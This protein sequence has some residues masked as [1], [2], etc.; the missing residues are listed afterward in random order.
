MFRLQRAELRSSWSTWLGVS[1]AFI[2]TNFALVLSALTLVA[3]NRAVRSG[4]LDPLDSTAFVYNPAQNLVFSA[5]VG[6]VVIGTAT[7]LALS[8]R[9]GALARLALTGA[10]PAQIVGTVMVQL[11]VV[12]LASSLVG[13]LLA[14]LALTPT[15]EFLA[16]ERIQAGTPMPAPE[17]VYA[18][19]P[20]A[21][22]TLGAVGV[23]VLGGLRQ[24]VRGSRVAPVEA[25]RSH[26]A[27]GQRIRMTVG[28]VIASC[29]VLL[30]LAGC[31][32]AVALLVREPNKETVSNLVVL[33]MA[34]LILMA[35]LLALLAPVLIG[36]LTRAWV[37]LLP[38][39]VASWQLARRTV[40]SRARRLTRSVVPVMMTIGLLLG[41][42]AIW[43]SLES[44]LIAN[45]YDI[46][47]SATGPSTLLVFLGLPLLI[48]LAGGVGSLI[49][50]SRQRDAELGLL[51]IVG[52][53]PRQRILVPLLEAVIIS[54][55]ATLLGLVMA[56]GA[57]A[58][59]ALGLPGAGMTYAFVPP[60]AMFVATITVTT[61]ITVGA[62]VL[63]TLRALREV[64]PV[65]VARLVAD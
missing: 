23:A 10:T 28:R 32:A 63:P 62:T 54:V 49:M 61:L 38:L 31:Y 65:L 50:M 27:D 44:T 41:M 13:T 37:R 2:A 47:M 21:L 6:M 57:L 51:G 60:V 8:A 15:L 18:L 53:S 22:T 30:V 3:G 34:V 64:E 36:P 58:V 16:Y 55:T 39:P 33:S 11:V 14:L 4:A 12:S 48:S 1:L 46:E 26:T 29:L 20:I 17:P 40:A 35:L 43:G 56:A 9:R 52:A 19:W 59:L 42:L 25:L 24:A 5:V 45:G 7:N